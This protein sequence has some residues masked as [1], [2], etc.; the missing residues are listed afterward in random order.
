M[1]ILHVVATKWGGG[2]DSAPTGSG[3]RSANPRIPKNYLPMILYN[4]PFGHNLPP[5]T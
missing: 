1:P 4:F 3:K 2:L 5:K